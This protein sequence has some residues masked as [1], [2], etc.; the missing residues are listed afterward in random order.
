MDRKQSTSRQ[1]EKELKTQ[2]A[3]DS[4]TSLSATRQ[5]CAK[6]RNGKEENRPYDDNSSEAVASFSDVV[7]PAPQPGTA[8][9]NK[10]N[11]SP[12]E[13]LKQTSSALREIARSSQNDL[14]AL[15]GNTAPPPDMYV[16]P[17]IVPPGQLAGTGARVKTTSSTTTRTEETKMETDAQQAL[18]VP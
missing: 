7:K 1:Q 3:I 10:D 4:Q 18:V 8:T 5:G 13:A 17:P 6:K 14:A 2:L 9:F 11:P 12:D 15:A 16:P